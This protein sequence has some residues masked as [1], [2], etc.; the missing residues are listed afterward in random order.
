MSKRVSVCDVC[1][2]AC[3]QRGKERAREKERERESK[4]DQKK[5]ILGS[6]H[7]IIAI[8]CYLF[9]FLKYVTRA[10]QCSVSVANHV[11]AA[12]RN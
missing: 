5:H 2:H 10:G 4:R 11:R 6:Y 1:A 3:D 12:R 8:C 7:Q 9:L